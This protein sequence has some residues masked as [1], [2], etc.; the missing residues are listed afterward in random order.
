LEIAQLMAMPYLHDNLFS[1]NP[2][3][4]INI[5]AVRLKN[6]IYLCAFFSDE[7]KMDRRMNFELGVGMDSNTAGLMF[8]KNIFSGINKAS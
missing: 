7:E 1:Y 3:F 8:Q 4:G 6:K 5:A 2:N